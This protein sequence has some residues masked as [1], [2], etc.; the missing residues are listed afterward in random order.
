MDRVE[1]SAS[2]GLG[3]LGDIDCYDDS[4]S[5][6]GDEDGSTGVQSAS[7]VKNILNG[8]ISRVVRDGDDV[9][10]GEEDGDVRDSYWEGSEPKVK[11]ELSVS[12]L[13]PI[14]DLFISVPQ[15][16]A[17]LIGRIFSIVDS[18]VVVKS[19]K[20]LPA[21]DLDS[22]L[23]LDYGKKALG[24]VFDVMGP[25]SD[26]FYVVRFNSSS[27]VKN[28][29]LCVGREVFYAPRQDN[30][31]SYVFFAQLR[32]MKGSD[33]SWLDDIEP[34]IEFIDYSDDEEE[35]Q[36]KK[37]HKKRKR[38]YHPPDPE[39]VA[40]NPFYRRERGYNPRANGP[41]TWNTW[42]PGQGNRSSIPP[43]LPGTSSMSNAPI[44]NNSHAHGYWGH[45]HPS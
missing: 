39:Q 18:L 6:S 23:F 11:G 24:T 7:L 36:A 12:E 16:Q 44:W 34:P 30:L 31:T 28:K 5:D 25:V 15:E 32:A 1:I 45:R 8:V 26:P 33:A 42:T 17:E 38:A 29:S 4:S 2:G 22:V 21:I 19:L 37:V 10:S 35:R 27:H 13:P 9:S 41:L 3:A 20:G 43:P 14:E 40:N